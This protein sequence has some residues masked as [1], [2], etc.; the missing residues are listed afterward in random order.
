M[1]RLINDYLFK[2]ATL[3]VDDDRGVEFTDPNAVSGPQVAGAN[4]NP[5]GT[6]AGTGDVEASQGADTIIT[7][8]ATGTDLGAGTYPGTNIPIPEGNIPGTEIPWEQLPNL[9]PDGDGNI[10][11]TNIPFPAPDG[12]G[13]IPGT[14]I[15]FPN[16]PTPS[17]QP[18]SGS[19]IPY[20]PHQNSTGQTEPPSSEMPPGQN[21]PVVNSPYPG[22]A[23]Q[24]PI[25]PNTGQ[26]IPETDWG[27]VP[28]GDIPK[29]ED[30]NG[31]HRWHNQTEAQE[32]GGKVVSEAEFKNGA[33]DA[34]GKPLKDSFKTYQDYLDYEF[35]HQTGGVPDTSGEKYEKKYEGGT[36]GAEGTAQ[37][38]EQ[39]LNL[40][41]GD[42]V[43][44]KSSDVDQSLMAAAPDLAAAND[45]A[46]VVSD[47]NGKIS[48]A[49]TMDIKWDELCDAYISLDNLLDYSADTVNSMHGSKGVPSNVNS[50]FADL[51]SVNGKLDSLKTAGACLNNLGD[52]GGGTLS[53]LYSNLGNTINLLFNADADARSRFGI[54]DEGSV[55]EKDI[56]FAGALLEMAKAGDTHNDFSAGYDNPINAVWKDPQGRT[57]IEYG[58]PATGEYTTAVVAEGED[59]NGNKTTSLITYENGSDVPSHIAITTT[60]DDGNVIKQTVETVTDNGDGTYS[61]E[62]R[63]EIQN[64]DGKSSTIESKGQL[65]DN[66][67]LAKNREALIND[68]EK[69]GI[70]DV[71]ENAPIEG[72]Q[73]GKKYPKPIK[74]DDNGNNGTGNTDVDTG[75]GTNTPIDNT[76]KD[77][78]PIDNTP[79]DNTPKDNTPADKQPSSPGGPGGPGTTPTGG[80][81]P[82]N[83]QPNNTQPNNTQPNNIQPNNTQPNNPQPPA[84]SGDGGNH[85]GG[86]GGS[87]GGYGGK[88]GEVV[89]GMNTTTDMDAITTNDLYN[90]P[91]V[92]IISEDNSIH[93]AGT[94]TQVATDMAPIGGLVVDGPTETHLGRNL[95]VA[96]AIGLAAG[97][98]AYGVK[99]VTEDE[100]DEETEEEE[101]YDY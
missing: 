26:P 82:N 43:R 83:T 85:G 60:D 46:S 6:F 11:G 39:N 101:S 17:P 59:M 24:T 88:T 86:G 36:G 22:S 18:N 67:D 31:N 28:T 7:D 42:D 89:D 34:M 14:N 27:N 55:Q 25:D 74:N 73:L 97:A 29:G 38:N 94:D 19:N 8:A 81:Q 45:N 95:G 66:K 61:W 9:G 68:D 69:L 79:K 80:T 70:H 64:E 98:A 84:P 44:Q 92:E 53:G 90:G 65:T 77:N 57:H 76:P 33:K 35:T 58:D 30:K 91:V 56:D 52:K 72:N 50:K 87:H 1:A 32:G 2:E 41:S 10:P 40:G 5:Q 93:T 100:G 54:G 49:D 48:D 78:T 20:W 47:E 37:G 96:A 63:T 23:P 21:V 4:G 71:H 12:N 99:K 75:N 16:I 3:Y 15:P 13:N 62:K 51:D